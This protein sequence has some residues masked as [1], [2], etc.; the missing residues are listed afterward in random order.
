[1]SASLAARVRSCR[2]LFTVEQT[3]DDADGLREPFDPG[4]SGIE[5]Q[6]GFVVLG[7]HVPRAQPELQT[8]I[9]Q[10]VGCR[11]LPGHQHGVPEV[12]VE[13]VGPHAER[14]R[15]LRSADQCGYGREDLGEV[16]GYRQN[17]VSK[18]LAPPRLV[19]PFGPG[20]SGPGVHAEAKRLHHL[21]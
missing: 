14:L 2:P 6:P 10:D 16:I 12:V 11:R 7:F 13:H 5:A 18:V 8:A 4:A 19:P 21:W 1:M 20:S 9:G 15:R 17:G 3:L